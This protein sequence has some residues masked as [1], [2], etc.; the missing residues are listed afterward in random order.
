MAKNPPANVQPL[1]E[2]DSTQGSWARVSQLLS[3]C[4]LEPVLCNREAT[5]TRSLHTTTRE[6]PCSLQLEK[7]CTATKPQCSQRI[8]PIKEGYCCVVLR[9]VSSLVR[10]GIQPWLFQFYFLFF[11]KLLR[12]R[13]S[14]SLWKYLCH[15]VEK[16]K[17][18]E[19]YIVLAWFLVLN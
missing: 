13:A 19:A 5:A 4:T 12:L 14:T 15:N 8:S 17:W 6:Y 2:E 16:M 1:V 18:D 10:C 3:L 11:G 7:A 9:I